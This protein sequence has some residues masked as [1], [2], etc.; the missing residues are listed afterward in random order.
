MATISPSFVTIFDSEVKQAYQAARQLAGLV[1]EKSVTGDTVK[2]NKLTKGVA[3]VRTPQTEVTPM[4]L[5]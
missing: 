2:F 1:R 3:A 5:T 4:N